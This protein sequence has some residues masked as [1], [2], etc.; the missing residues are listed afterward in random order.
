MIGNIKSNGR[1]NINKKGLL[2]IVLYTVK[3]Y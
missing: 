2:K 1:L 3:M